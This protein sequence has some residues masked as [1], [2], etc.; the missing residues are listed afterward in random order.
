[1]K[2]KAIITGSTGMVG[3]GILLE[4][5]ENPNVET[6]LVVNRKT[7]GT[8]HE[9]LKEIIHKDFYNLEEIENELEDYNACYFSLGISSI[10]MSEEDY[11]KITYDLAINFA[12]TLLEK[13]KEMTFCYVSGAGTD[14][15]EKGKTMWARVKGK[16]ENAILAMPFKNSFAFRPAYIQPIGEV[17]SKT[18]LYDFGIQIAKHLYPILKVIFPNHT[19]TSQAIGKAMINV[20]LN[21]YEQ[22][23]IESKDINIL[24]KN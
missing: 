20:V 12:K 23:V 18:R 11:T 17:K 13:N 14:S 16:T 15:S 9:K 8:K 22:R 2:I 21:G 10:G 6:V 3:K 1:M 4:C 24:A 5:L 19:T 7:I